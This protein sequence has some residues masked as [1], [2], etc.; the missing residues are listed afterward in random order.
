MTC[1]SLTIVK[2]TYRDWAA[3]G[4]GRVQA[5]AFQTVTSGYLRLRFRSPIEP[6]DGLARR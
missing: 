2:S 1:L 4:I 6:T 5:L 3:K